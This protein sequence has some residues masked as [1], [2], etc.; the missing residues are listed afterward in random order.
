MFAVPG[1]AGGH[2]VDADLVGR[3]LIPG[4]RERDALPQGVIERGRLCI[5]RIAGRYEPTSG[6]TLSRMG[7]PTA[8][9]A[10]PA[11]EYPAES[12]TLYFHRS[13]PAAR[14]PTLRRWSHPPPER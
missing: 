4:V 12:D 8:E 2:I 9:S 5:G 13:T 11:F 3:V 6:L 14:N 1:D 10:G 7:Q